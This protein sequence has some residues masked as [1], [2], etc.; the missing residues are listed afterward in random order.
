MRG[1]G[2]GNSLDIIPSSLKEQIRAE[3]GLE[4]NDGSR[5]GAK[6]PKIIGSKSENMDIEVSPINSD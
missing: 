4:Q 6:L 3:S 2:I 1:V 5:D